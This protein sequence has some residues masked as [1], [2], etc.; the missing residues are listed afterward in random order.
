MQE[1][2]NNQQSHKKSNDSQKS[3]NTMSTNMMSNNTESNL[4]TRFF[5]LFKKY[6][7]L[8]KQGLYLLEICQNAAG[9]TDLATDRRGHDG[10]SWTPSSHTCAIS[11]A[12]LF[13]TLDGKHD[14]PSQTGR[15]VEGLRSKIHQL[16]EYGYWD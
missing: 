7:H 8:I 1:S 15:S 12:A 16:L 4:K 13:I 5:E 10:P 6:K 14:R 3:N 9:S 2:Q 11:S